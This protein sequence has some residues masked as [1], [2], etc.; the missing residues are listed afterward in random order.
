MIQTFKFNK[1]HCEMHFSPRVVENWEDTILYYGFCSSCPI[2]VKFDK[3]KGVLA[4]FDFREIPKCGEDELDYNDTK[5]LKFIK[6]SKLNSRML[7]RK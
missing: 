6:L 7:L 2:R 1:C 3:E 4:L 5:T